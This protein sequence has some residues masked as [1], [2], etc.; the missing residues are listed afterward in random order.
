MSDMATFVC[1]QC[2]INVYF[3][4]ETAPPPDGLCMECRVILDAR[5]EDRAELA[6]VF[7]K[8]EAFRV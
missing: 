8:E 2:G 1:R 5:P 7:R 3:I 4:V 6:R